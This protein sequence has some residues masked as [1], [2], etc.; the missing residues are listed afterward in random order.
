M[1]I[2]GW[3]HGRGSKHVAGCG[4][5][6]VSPAAALDALSSSG[7]ALLIDI[8]SAKE[9]ETSGLPDLPSSGK[10]V[11]LEFATVADRKL[12]GQLRNPGDLELKVCVGARGSRE[13]TLLT[14]GVGLCP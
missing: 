1:A 12:R 2:G 8:R 4:A 14:V 6:E 5:G 10:L 7:G 3:A 13:V 9:K 11:E